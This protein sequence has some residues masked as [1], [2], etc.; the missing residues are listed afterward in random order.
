MDT[1]K[2]GVATAKA[3]EEI[4][5]LHAKGSIEED[6]EIAAVV[7]CVALDAPTPEDAPDRDE[8][9][10]VCTQTFAFCEPDNLYIQL[11]V[12]RMVEMNYG[13]IAHDE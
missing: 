10:D 4:D 3:M 7:I 8:L 11:G 13:P 1:T 12:L 9:R 6:A 5:R 2:L